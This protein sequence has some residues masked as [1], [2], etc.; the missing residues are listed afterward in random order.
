MADQMRKMETIRSI[1]NLQLSNTLISALD[2]AQTAHSV[3][4]AVNEL[5]RFS[6]QWN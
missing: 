1:E 4:D 3:V 5:I 6:E 2:D